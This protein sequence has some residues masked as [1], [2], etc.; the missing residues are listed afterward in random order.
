MERIMTIERHIIE[1][2]RGH[3][4]ATG[5]FSNLLYDVA[6]AAKVIARETGRAG[7]G[8]ILGLSG[9]INVQGE[10]QMKLDV[11]AHEM[12]VRMNSF[13]GRLAAMASE[14]REYIIPIPDQYRTGKYVLIFD[15]L[16]GSS[17][18][19]VNA[20]VGTIFAIYRRVSRDGPGTL[21]DFLQSGRKLEAAGYVIYGPS[22][23]L[24]YTTGTGVHGFTLDPELGEF[25]LSHPVMRFPETPKYYSV[26]QGNEKYW[27]LGVQRY[28]KWL[29]GLDPEQP[30]QEL[31]SRY[32]G[33]LVADFHR[34]LLDGGVYYYP[35]DTKDA[36]KPHGKLRLMYEAVPLSFIA[37]QAGGKGSDGTRNI[38]S[39][40]PESLHQRTP[41]FVGHY[42]L[43]EKAEEYIRRFDPR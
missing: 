15:P 28:T 20:S 29:Q 22:T 35:A 19:D 3:P 5:V 21:Q 9:S 14:E 43:V 37:E 6:L 24:V 36:G 26:N 38:L 33:S 17:N 13:A 30:R 18:I 4:G 31:S 23:M 2:E 11:F 25:L 7:L 39:I 41:L 42:E 12:M 1:Q 34:N 32:I 27:S 10:Q 40:E 8:Q 16:D